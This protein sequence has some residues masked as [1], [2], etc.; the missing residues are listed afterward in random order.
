RRPL[1]AGGG[2]L[3]GADEPAGYGASFSPSPAETPGYAQLPDLAGEAQ[4]ADA[5]ARRQVPFDSAGETGPD[6]APA[7]SAAPAAPSPVPEPEPEESSY[8]APQGGGDSGDAGDGGEGDGGSYE[9]VI[10]IVRSG[11]PWVPST[12][13]STVP[14]EP[15]EPAE[16][17]P[18]SGNA[19]GEAFALRTGAAPEAPEM[20]SETSQRADV[21]SEEHAAA[22]EPA[23]DEPAV[24]PAPD[25]DP[26]PVPA[27]QL[28]AE[29]PHVSYV[30]HVNGA[31][32][33]VTDA[34]IGESL[35]YVLR[36]RLGLAGAK[37]GCAQG[38]CGACSVQVDGRLLAS[39]LV[40]SA[41]AAGSE[42]R[43]VEGL[44]VDGTPSDVQRALT[45]SGAVQCGF[46]VPGLAMTVHDL[47]EGNHAPSELETRQA[48]CGNLCRCSGYRGVLD[49]VNT[50][51]SER[52]AAAER[53]TADRD[54]AEADAHAAHDGPQARIPHQA[55]PGAGGVQR[56]GGGGG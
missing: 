3:P 47:L 23:Q 41:T 34:W 26:D 36:E 14:A 8:A 27:P 30:L 17:A 51:V 45:E 13:S 33:P 29:H 18:E 28:D 56:P 55:G 12:P 20:P 32:R 10:P 53:D 24:D 42:I 38:E 44:A 22:P 11:L 50:V 37:D 31:D 46:C 9:P 16:G 40:P 21:P 1:G 49:A 2:T 52:S 39:C 15:A 6:S 7:A 43:T 5:H 35:L 25:Q 4:F 19:W 48:I 54:A